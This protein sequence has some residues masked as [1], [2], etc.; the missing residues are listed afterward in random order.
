MMI[1]QGAREVGSA[2][3]EQLEAAGK[4][5]RAA[6]AIVASS[7]LCVRHDRFGRQKHTSH[8]ASS[9]QLNRT[10]G[11]QLK[12]PCHR[13][14]SSSL[15]NQMPDA[16]PQ[17]DSQQSYRL[18]KGK[19]S[20]SRPPHGP[21]LSGSSCLP[22]RPAAPWPCSRTPR[23]RTPSTSGTAASHHLAPCTR[24]ARAAADSPPPPPQSAQTAA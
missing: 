7:P 6:T 3:R 12:P 19:A 17:G 23:N 8:R 18:L 11:S 15:R 4:V 1:Q 13:W 16:T 21:S 22:P 2:W 9:S 10:S 14:D 5:P 20:P 24:P